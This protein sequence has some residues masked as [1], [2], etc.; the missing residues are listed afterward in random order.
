MLVD[1]HDHAYGSR[2][3]VI[4]IRYNNTVTAPPEFMILILEFAVL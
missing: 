2:Y 3:S 4:F 1:Q